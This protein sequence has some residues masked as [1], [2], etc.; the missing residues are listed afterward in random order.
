MATFLDVTGLQYFSSLFVFIFSWGVLYSVL[1]LSKVF[2]ENKVIP[3][4]LSA[5][6]SFF[7]L[8]NPFLVDLIQTIAPWMGFVFIFVILLIVSMKLLVPGSEDL[9]F[10]ARAATLIVILFIFVIA[11]AVKV[12]EAYV[13]ADAKDR[14]DFSKTGN[15]LLHPKVLGALL[16]LAIAVL[17][18]GLLTAKNF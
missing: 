5:V 7:M 1:L 13:P 11:I 2:G 6:M 12:K 3:A 17:T 14:E 9:T 18:V 16:L 10:P 15:V 4:V 8:F